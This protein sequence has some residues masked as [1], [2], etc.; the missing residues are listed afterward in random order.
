MVLV[1]RIANAVFSKG[2]AAVRKQTSFI[3]RLRINVKGGS[4][5]QGFPKYGGIGGRGGDVYVVASKHLSLKSVKAKC[6][7]QKYTAEAGGNSKVHRLMG[8][9]GQDLEIPVP[10]GICI[11][12]DNGKA[13][14][15]MNEVGMKVKVATGGIGGGPENNF[16]GQ[17]GV[18]RNIT[19]DLKLIADIGLV[20]FPNAG[21]STLL[22]AVS[23]AAPKI[24]NYPFTTIK[25]QLG[26]MMYED[27]RQ[28]TVADLPGLIEGAH[29]NFGMGHSFL[30]HVER[31]KMLLLVVDVFGFQL[32][33]EH[34]HRTAFETILLLNKELE[35]YKPELL[36]KPAILALNKTDMEG[37]Q[38]KLHEVVDKLEHVEKLIKELDDTFRP[39][40]LM[41]FD[42]VV[43][44]SAK[45]KDSVGWLQSRVREV[46]DYYADQRYEAEHTELLRKGTIKPIE[47]PTERSK[48]KLV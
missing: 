28:I 14:G 15:D 4:G 34:P 25:P 43:H 36:E 13:I 7:K 32:S 30:K 33:N 2:K 5:G 37:A 31:T 20:G 22:G 40:Q 38:E 12:L 26:T 27:N 45:K 9:P 24:A 47:M 44:I 16:A 46:L 18:S 11:R 19:L 3:D 8:P 48:T 39:K 41:K 6:P 23:R 29:V 17:R 42:D 35:L 10:T 1:S 21:K